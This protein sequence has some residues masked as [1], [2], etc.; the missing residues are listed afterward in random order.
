MTT[1]ILTVC[2][3]GGNPVKFERHLKPLADAA[4]QTVVCVTAG[5][6]MAGVTYRTVPD[7]GVRSL[8]LVALGVYALVEALT[9]DYDGVVSFSLLPYGC[10]ALVA[11]RFG[12]IPVHLGII[13]IDL[14]VHADSRYG[15]VVA[16]LF[17]RFDVVSVPGTTYARRLTDL[18]VSCE[19]ISVLINPIDTTVYRPPVD[20]GETLYDCLWV[21]RFSAEKGPGRFVEAIDWLVD[22]RPGVD[23]AMVGDGPVRD[24]VVAE[25]A[26]RGLSDVIEL[27][28]WVE[29][30]VRY[31]Q[32]SLVFV[33]TSERDAMP[34][35]LLEAMATGTVPVVS[36]VG[37]VRDVARDGVNA[38]V[39]DERSPTAIAEAVAELLGDPERL[40]RLGRRASRIRSEYSYEAATEGWLDVLEGL[41]VP[42]SRDHREIELER[43]LTVD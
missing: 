40:D 3:F 13:G 2:D 27:P 9:G 31:Y 17:R 29:S 26:D 41:G 35:T 10:I 5:P 43:N 30:P 22:E 28:G 37:N 14:D 1:S 8:G 23:V 32:R 4:D 25:I 39:L 11:G 20:D 19:R 34:L 7:G 18:R 38:R 12:G 42:G 15:S 16:W 21:G 24:A 33:L 6:S 36:D